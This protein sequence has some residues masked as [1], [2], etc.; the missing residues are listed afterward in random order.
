MVDWQNPAPV[1]GLVAVVVVI[2]VVVVV[3]VVMLVVVIVIIIIVAVVVVLVNK[4][5]LMMRKRWTPTMAVNGHDSW[6]KG[7]SNYELSTTTART[8]A[9]LPS[10]L[11]RPLS[12]Q[13]LIL[14]PANLHLL[15]PLLLLRLLL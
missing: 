13:A 15:L 9:H 2:V 3:V 12:P 8:S 6:H 1:P 10:L 4:K 5:A 11:Q 7:S 14:S